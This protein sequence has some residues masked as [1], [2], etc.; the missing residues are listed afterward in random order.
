MM[1]FQE[2]VESRL[3]IEGVTPENLDAEFSR[4]MVEMIP[5]VLVMLGST[6]GVCSS[7]PEYV[8]AYMHRVLDESVKSGMQTRLMVEAPTGTIQ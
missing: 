2:W 7:D 5:E 4:R 6:V 1:T 3:R 8:L